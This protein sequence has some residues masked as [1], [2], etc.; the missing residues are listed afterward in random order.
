[1]NHFLPIDRLCEG[2]HWEAF[3]HPQPA[4]PLHIL[5][6]PKQLMPAL[7]EAT[8]EDPNLYADL[9]RVVQKLISGLKLE[10]RGYRLVTNGGPNQSI[11]IWHWHLIC[12]ESGKGSENPGVAYD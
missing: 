9:F 12:E 3:Y 5:I 1:M 4:Y 8:H 10:D 6:L 7:V 2:E 11:P